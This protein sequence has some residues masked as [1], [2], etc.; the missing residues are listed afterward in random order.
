MV[1]MLKSKNVR[2]LVVFYVGWWVA[3]YLV[4]LGQGFL[5]FGVLLFLVTLH[6][7]FDAHKGEAVFIFLLSSF[8][9]LLDGLLQ[10]VGLLT[11]NSSFYERL[12]PLWHYGLWMLFACTWF[13]SM[14]WASRSMV[15]GAL[16]GALCGPLTYYVA[17]HRTGLMHYSLPILKPLVIH[18]FIWAFIMILG[19]SY[20]RWGAKRRA[21]R[22][23]PKETPNTP[24]SHER[25]HGH[26]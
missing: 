19:I 7:R 20:D 18:G 9:Y 24:P 4:A 16:M 1:K 14:G 2:N 26:Q 13:H 23:L 5:A 15:S 10:Y 8:G 3:I 22:A 21:P 17:G 25:P 11:F 12:P 6:V